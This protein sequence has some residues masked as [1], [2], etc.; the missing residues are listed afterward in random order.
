MSGAFYIRYPAS[1]GSNASVGV[2]G[3]IAPTSATE[4]GGI[5][6]GGLLQPVNIDAAGNLKVAVTSGP[7]PNTNGQQVTSAVV[8]SGAA[9]SF[10]PPANAVGFVLEAESGNAQNLR[11][12]IV[13][14]PTTTSGMLMEPGRDT[15]Y[16]PCAA[17]VRVIAVAGTN[18]SVGIQWILSA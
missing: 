8:G 10:A 17:T 15:G 13:T 16:I 6:P 9:V 12:A 7:A 1:G 2:T 18:Q 5:G 4:I 3:S 14:V 11:W